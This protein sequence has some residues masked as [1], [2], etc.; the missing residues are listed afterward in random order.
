MPATQNARCIL[1]NAAMKN[2]NEKKTSAYDFSLH[3]SVKIQLYT[4][5]VG[6]SYGSAQ[7]STCELE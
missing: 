5:L 6:G 1:T 4:S 7:A 2:K 3:V